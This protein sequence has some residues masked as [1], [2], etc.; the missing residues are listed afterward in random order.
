MIKEELFAKEK[1]TKEKIEFKKNQIKNL[2]KSIKEK[3]LQIG[4]LKNE[5]KTLQEEYNNIGYSMLPIL[6]FVLDETLPMPDNDWDWRYEYIY[7]CPDLDKTKYIIEHK[8]NKFLPHTLD[9]RDAFKE[10]EVP[11]KSWP[12]SAH[13]YSSE[14]D[15]AVFTLKEQINNL[16]DADKINSFS[17]LAEQLTS[18]ASNNGQSKVLKPNNLPK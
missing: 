1:F 3:E 18:W 7:Y 6:L 13:D 16:L 5:L 11:Q 4:Q 2:E 8:E 9:L 17:D 15:H 12:K 14:I 10:F